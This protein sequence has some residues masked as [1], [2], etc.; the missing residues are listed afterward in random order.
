M[1][2]RSQNYQILTRQPVEI[3]KNK[4]GIVPFFGLFTSL[5]FLNNRNS[6]LDALMGGLVF[7][8]SCFAGFRLACHLASITNSGGNSH[9]GKYVGLQQNPDSDNSE[10]D[11]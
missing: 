10:H 1:L 9:F 4:I 3:I 5:S 11:E 2:V 6:A 8:V 7:I